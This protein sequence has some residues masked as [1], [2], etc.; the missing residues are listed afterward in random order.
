LGHTWNPELSYGIVKGAIK[1]YELFYESPK[2]GEH[3]VG[4]WLREKLGFLAE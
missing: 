3:P 2:S 1:A 4:T